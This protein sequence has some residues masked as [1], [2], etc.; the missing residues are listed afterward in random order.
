MGSNMIEATDINTHNT[1]EKVAYKEVKRNMAL[2]G[3]NMDKIESFV[4]LHLF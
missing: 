2:S 1:S 4:L 3:E